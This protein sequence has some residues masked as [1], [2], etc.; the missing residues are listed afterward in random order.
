MTTDIP[1]RALCALGFAALTVTPSIVSAQK[2]PDFAAFDAYVAKAAKD[3]NTAGLAIAIVKG[4]SLVFAKGYGSIEVGKPA[5]INEH[6]RFAIGST[7]KAMTSAS[8]AMLA[9]EGKIHWDDHV[10]DYIPELRLY[11]AY[12]SHELTIR[13]ILT[14]RS[15]LP[16]TDLFWATDENTPPFNEM[17]RRLR[18]IKPASSFRS[19]WDYQNVVYA[20]GGAIIERVS[21]MPWDAFIRTRIFAPLGM[22]ESEALVS[23]IR[24]KANVA[25][26]HRHVRDSLVPTPI[27]STDGVAAAGSVY[28]SV[29]DMSKWMRFILDSGRVGDKRLIS[30]ANFRELIAPQIRAPMEQYPSLELVRPNFFSYAFG[31]FVQDYHGQTVWMHTGSINGMSAIIGLEPDQRVGVYVLENTDHVELRHALIYQ[32]FDLYNT[33]PKRDWSKDLLAFYNAQRPPARPATA[34]AQAAAAQTVPSKP[35]R[36]LDRYAGAYVDSAYGTI[37]VKAAGD[38]LRASWDKIDFGVID[39]LQGDT[40][41]SRATPQIGPQPFAFQV[42]EQGAVSGVRALGNLFERARRA[43]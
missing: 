27:R 23:Q 40:F 4:D 24:G 7:T 34:A 39:F 41:R 9:D 37:T 35:P 43:P 21:G 14:H 10:T 12:A 28:S 17:M 3:W 33:G 1:R 20:I 8:L 18:Y 42:N 30:I 22:T 19:T 13:D 16:G 36:S 25:V 11:D 32:G 38:T 31:W 29:S 15:G 2:G 6:T 26:P 5:K